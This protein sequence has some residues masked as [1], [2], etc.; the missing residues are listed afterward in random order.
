MT[1]LRAPQEPRARLRAATREDRGAPTGLSR[2]PPGPRVRPRAGFGAPARGPATPAASPVPGV[3]RGR[4]RGERT[5][6]DDAVS[7]L[8][9]GD[10]SD[11]THQLGHLF[12]VT[13]GRS[14]ST[15]LQGVLNSIPGYLIRGENDGA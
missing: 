4:P 6:K 12:I 8:P 14:G 10:R 5:C 11:D 3:R 7:S 15:L 13:Y 9:A 1:R 2:P